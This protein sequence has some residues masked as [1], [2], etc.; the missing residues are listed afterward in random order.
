MLRNH[1]NPALYEGKH[2]FVWQYGEDLIAW[3]A[4]QPGE[5]ILDLGCGTGQL[6]QTIAQSGAEVIGIDHSAT[7]IAQARQHYPLLEFAVAD[8]RQL[9]SDYPCRE[10]QSD[11]PFDAVF[12]N[13]VLHW[14]LEAD[15]V[16]QSVHHVL[17]PGGRFVAE[18]GGCGNVQEIVQSLHKARASL[19]NPACSPWY[20][21]SLSEYATRLEQ[22]GFEVRQAVLF[23]RPTPLEEGDAGLANWIHMFASR[24][25][26][27]LS[28][29][30]QIQVVQTVEQDLKP[31]LHRDGQWWAD[32]RRLRIMATKLE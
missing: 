1:W 19:H 26:D 18:F 21:P 14:I 25:L 32:Y 10:Q 15:A 11:R 5:R 24:F 17:K 22:H 13:A 20:F 7:M 29:E 28:A 30:Q 23:D 4:P 8:A 31:T 9:Q 12:S 2:A 6:T 3:L 27:D 16:I